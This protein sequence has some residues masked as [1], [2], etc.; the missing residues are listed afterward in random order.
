MDLLSVRKQKSFKRI[1]VDH[2]ISRSINVK[3]LKFKLCFVNRA[4]YQFYGY[5]SRSK[6][7][8]DKDDVFKL[9]IYHKNNDLVFKKDYII[10]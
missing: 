8:P 2:L 5:S 3:G 6:Y 10:K 7:Y 1:T 4:G 9:K